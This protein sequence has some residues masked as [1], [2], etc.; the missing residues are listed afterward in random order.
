MSLGNT[1]SLCSYLHSASVKQSN[2]FSRDFWIAD[3]GESYHMTNNNANM[4]DARPPPPVRKWIMIGNR[5][6]HR[7]EYIGSMHAA[8]KSMCLMFPV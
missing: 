6:R 2:S 8:I 3:S 4:Y 1:P 7:V 5:R